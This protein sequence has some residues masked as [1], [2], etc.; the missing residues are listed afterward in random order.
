[1]G[2]RERLVNMHWM[3]KYVLRRNPDLTKLL[4]DAR[5]R[6]DQLEKENEDLKLLSSPEMVKTVIDINNQIRR[7]C[8]KDGEK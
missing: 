5:K 6:I 7:N 1:M 2:V 8:G 3:Y 4:D